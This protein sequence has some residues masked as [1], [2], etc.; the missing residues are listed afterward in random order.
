VFEELS[1]ETK[2]E[3]GKDE[4]EI[5]SSD[6]SSIKLSSYRDIVLEETKCVEIDL[7]GY[8]SA[9]KHKIREYF[10]SIFGGAFVK[11]LPGLSE[12]KLIIKDCQ[13]NT[14]EDM[15]LLP[16]SLDL[17]KPVESSLSLG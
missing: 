13:V 17:L 14:L 2:N 3:D 11:L 4:E 12:D 1:K 15:K 5:D 6:Q 10:V 8:E 7:N 16:F 9:L